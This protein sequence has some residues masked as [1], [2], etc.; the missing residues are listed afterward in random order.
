MT[1]TEANKTLARIQALLAKAESTTHPEEAQAFSA[2]AAELMAKYAVSDEALAGYRGATK[3]EVG[4]SRIDFPF[5]PYQ[6]PRQQLLMT[7]ASHNDCKVVFTQTRRVVKGKYVPFSVAVLIGFGRDREFTEVLYTSLLVQAEMEFRSDKVQ[8]LMFA[9]TSHP[10]HR[11]K[12]RNAY[13]MGYAAVIRIRL[14]AIKREARKEASKGVGTDLVLRDKAGLVRSKQDELFPRL[15]TSR[16]S[17]GG[18]SGS[19][20]L[21]GADAA[22]RANLGSPTG[23]SGSSAR[24]A[25]S[26]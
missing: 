19:G 2:K 12:W 22:T 20:R 7:V 21:A 9:E 1:E 8:A 24:G 15:G 25:L 16:S 14:E 6:S 11:I 23:V 18:G 3:A 10:G 26:G 13:T 17:A 4:T 5:S